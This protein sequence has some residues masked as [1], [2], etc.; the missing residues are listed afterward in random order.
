MQDIKNRKY[1][2]TRFLINTLYKPSTFIEFTLKIES[3]VVDPGN[4]SN[5]EAFNICKF[6]SSCLLCYFNT[7]M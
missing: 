4:M 5:C 1:E 3:K 6:G 7:G 2:T